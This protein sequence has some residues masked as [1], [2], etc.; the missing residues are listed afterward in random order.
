[1]VSYTKG[2]V[3]KAS[4]I[5]DC[6]VIQLPKISDPRGNLT[7]IES[8]RHIKFPIKRVYYL[9]DVPGGAER[10]GHAHKQLYQFVIAISGS[11]DVVLDDGKKQKTIHLNRSYAGLIICPY[12]W[13]E[14]NNFSTGAMCLVLASEYFSEKD[15]FRNYKAFLR[16]RKQLKGQ[17]G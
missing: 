10:G 12:I 2:Q 6:K 13:R 3:V 16:A 11:F 9:Y 8:E 1:M 7:Y 4:S 17:K 15:Y 5:R 14:L